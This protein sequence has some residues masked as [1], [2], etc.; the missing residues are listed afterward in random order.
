MLAIFWYAYAQ[1]MDLPWQYPDFRSC[2]TY[3][4][5][6]YKNGWVSQG[7]VPGCHTGIGADQYVRYWKYVRKMEVLLLTY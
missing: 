5:G 7:A 4:E 2:T 6:A 3:I 1:I